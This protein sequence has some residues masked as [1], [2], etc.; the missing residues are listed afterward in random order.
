MYLQGR[1]P[2]HGSPRRGSR[3]RR[4]RREQPR[5]SLLFSTLAL[6]QS[7]EQSPVATLAGLHSHIFVREGDYT[8]NPSENFTF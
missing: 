1:Y 8:Y 7:S 2:R 5:T 4:T 3:A 6:D